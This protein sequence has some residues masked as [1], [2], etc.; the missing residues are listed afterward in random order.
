MF[1]WRSGW[2]VV[3]LVD[4]LVGEG[5]GM[6]GDRWQGVTRESYGTSRV[7]MHVCTAVFMCVTRGGELSPHSTSVVPLHPSL[8]PLHP[9]CFFFLHRIQESKRDTIIFN[10]TLI[11]DI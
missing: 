8:V 4:D 10:N 11:M 3:C 1:G 6:D 5:T 9:Y 7:Y 2:L